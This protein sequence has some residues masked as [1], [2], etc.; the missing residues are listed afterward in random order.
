LFVPVLPILEL[1]LIDELLIRFELIFPTLLFMLEFVL[2][3]L[4]MFVDVL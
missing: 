1:L 4:F 3:L 2:K